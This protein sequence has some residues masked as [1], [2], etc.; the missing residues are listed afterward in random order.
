MEIYNV[1]FPPIA[2]ADQ[3]FIQS[4][5]IRVLAGTITA[6]RHIPDD[7]DLALNWEHGGC[8]VLSGRPGHFSSGLPSARALDG[9]I[10]VEHTFNLGEPDS[11]GPCEIQAVITTEKPD[12]AGGGGRKLAFQQMVLSPAPLLAPPGVERNAGVT[13]LNPPFQMSATV[14]DAKTGQPVHEFFLTPRFVFVSGTSTNLG[15]WDE[16]EGR[17]GT[18]G[19]IKASYDHQLLVGSREIHD[20][21]FRIEASGY[22]PFVTRVVKDGDRNLKLDCPLQPAVVTESHEASLSPH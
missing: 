5:K 20:S 3:E 6:I 21:Q 9:F 19:K 22:E 12:P 14:T 16:Y 4:F 15:E 18:A 11:L 13:K 2:L 10:T 7:W 17:N 8:V 1:S